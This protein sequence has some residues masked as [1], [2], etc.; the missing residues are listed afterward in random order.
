MCVECL[1]P[2]CSTLSVTL[3]RRSAQAARRHRHLRRIAVPHL[4]PL[5]HMTPQRHPALKVCAFVARHTC[6]DRQTDRQTDRHA[7][8]RTHTH[9]IK[10]WVECSASRPDFVPEGFVAILQH[11]CTGRD[12]TTGHRD[13]QTDKHVGALGVLRGTK[14]RACLGGGDG[15]IAGLRPVRATHPISLCPH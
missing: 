15:R 12:E 6:T 3:R 8:T 11:S 2:P 1:I 13:R 4:M 10:G 5:L 14:Q 7:H 9:T